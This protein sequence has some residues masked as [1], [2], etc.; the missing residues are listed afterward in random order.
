MKAERAGELLGQAV[1]GHVHDVVP[2]VSL[3]ELV[4]SLC[5][6]CWAQCTPEAWIDQCDALWDRHLRDERIRACPG[7]RRPEITEVV[8]G[9]GETF[10][11]HGP[12]EVCGG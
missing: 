6:T 9:S 2:V 12:C 1:S 10:T 5:V 11:V 3:G 8:W 7:H 4:A